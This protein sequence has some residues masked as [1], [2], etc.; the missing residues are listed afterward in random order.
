MN[1]ASVRG[2]ERDRIYEKKLLK[3][4]KL[5]DEE[6]GDKPKFM[7]TAYKQKLIEDKKWEV[8]DKYVPQFCPI[9]YHFVHF[10]PFFINLF[11]VVL[12]AGSQM[13]LRRELMCDRRACMDSTQ[14]C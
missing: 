13:K 3:D 9:N 10:L 8:E 5:E 14:I 6:Y 11:D 1:T 12:Y 2:K 4:R 7:T